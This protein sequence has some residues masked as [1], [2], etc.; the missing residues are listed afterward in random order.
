MLPMTPKISLRGELSYSRVMY[1]TLADTL[2]FPIG[3]YIP[4]P[5]PLVTGAIV[6]LRR[7]GTLEMENHSS[8]QYR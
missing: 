1:D 2:N 5:I 7:S 8:I 6:A 3:L 4:I